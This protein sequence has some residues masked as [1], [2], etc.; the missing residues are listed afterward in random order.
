MTSFQG[1]V[2]V[3]VTV[4]SYIL[5][6]SPSEGRESN[7]RDSFISCS[8]YIDIWSKSG[9]GLEE[10]IFEEQFKNVIF[11]FEKMLDA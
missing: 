2:T 1:H 10:E 11:A 6:M 9:S 7:C 8:E 3:T 5:K 4:W